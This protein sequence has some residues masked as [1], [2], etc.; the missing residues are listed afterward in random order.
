[1]N[2]S[3]GIHRQD[4][5]EAPLPATPLARLSS[6]RLNGQLGLLCDVGIAL[7]LLAAGL[8]GRHAPI[9]GVAIFVAGI[10]L[11][12]FVEYAFHRW[13]FH[14]PFSMFERGH[15]RHHEQPEG[16]DALPFFLPPVAMGVLAVLLTGVMTRSNALLF[17]AAVAAGYALYGASHSV[18]HARRFRSLPLRRWAGA[19]HVHHHHPHTN[20][21]VTSPF[22]DVVFR[23]RYVS[24]QRN[25]AQ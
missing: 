16:Y 24:G 10:A 1:M 12:T 20:F 18:M 9:S 22:W 23:T 19:H 8:Y 11:F 7:V 21:G 17:A 14:G 5:V 2:E 25:A 6:S 3:Q 4:A 15:T 13:L